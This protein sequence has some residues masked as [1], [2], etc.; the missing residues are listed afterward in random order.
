MWHLEVRYL[1]YQISETRSVPKLVEMQRYKK[2]APSS[3]GMRI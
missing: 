3:D 1:L 2:C